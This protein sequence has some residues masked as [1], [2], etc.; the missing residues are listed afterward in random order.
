M[1]T[2]TGPI[3]HPYIRDIYYMGDTG[4]PW[5]NAAGML[6]G[7]CYVLYANDEE[8]P[9][10]WGFRPGLLVSNEHEH[11]REEGSFPDVM[12][13]DGYMDG[14]ITGT[15]LRRAGEVFHRYAKALERAGMSY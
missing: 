3:I 9:D 6:F 12:L 2:R 15:D 14:D 1:K 11:I 7:I 8:I 4:D 13:L 5:G 10:E